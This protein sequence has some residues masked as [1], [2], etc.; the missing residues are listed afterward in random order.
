M[1]VNIKMQIVTQAWMLS[2]LAGDTNTKEL[3]EHCRFQTLCFPSLR[4]VLEYNPMQRDADAF[5][6]SPA[7]G[8]E[9][10]VQRNAPKFRPLKAFI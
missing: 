7:L 9:T 2:C 6:L 1:C 5:T 10:Q 4:K 8:F 3:L